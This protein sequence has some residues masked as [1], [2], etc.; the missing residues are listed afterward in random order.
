MAKQTVTMDALIKRINRKLA[1][2]YQAVRK[3]RERAKL[4]LGEYYILDTYRNFIVD[5]NID[6]EDYARELRVMHDIET[7]EPEG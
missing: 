4:D 3:S 5:T 2:E 6:P 7:V 1:P